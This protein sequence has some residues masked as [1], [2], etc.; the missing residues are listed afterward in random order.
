MATVTPMARGAAVSFTFKYN[1]KK[2]RFLIF[3]RP[4]RAPLATTRIAGALKLKF[5]SY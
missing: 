2:L 4:L 5:I 1:F 3:D